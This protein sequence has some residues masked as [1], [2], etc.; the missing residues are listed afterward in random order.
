MRFY[1]TAN[2]TEE[3]RNNIDGQSARAKTE[4]AGTA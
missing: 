1:I 4:K 3:R 2:M